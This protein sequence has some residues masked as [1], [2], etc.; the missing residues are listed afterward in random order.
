[1]KPADTSVLINTYNHESYI[2]QCVDS[3]LSQTRRPG[4]IIVY[5]DGSSDGTVGLLRAYGN[6]VT[7]IEGPRVARPPHVAQG[8]AIHA[9]FARSSGNLVFLLDG[10]DRFKPSKIERFCDAFSEHPESSMIQSPMDK[11][12]ASGRGLGTNLEPR[13]HIPDHL[14]A[15]YRDQ[16]VDFFYPTSS[17]AFARPYLEKILPLDFSDNLPL[18]ADTRLSMTAPYFGRVTMLP[19]AY[20]DWRRHETSASIVERSESLQIRH[21]LMRARVFNRFCRRH[22]LKSISPWRN[23]RL[24]LQLAR[25]ALPRP[26]FSF[27]YD[28]VLASDASRP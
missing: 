20:S 3:V 5:D 27:V 12:D 14:Q 25:Y 8:N 13:K 19:D 17:L 18:W 2:T 9:A 23:T 6:Q 10:D 11:I 26:V 22:G 24:Y 21:T 4:E 16:D 1:M 28:R 15:I 7:L